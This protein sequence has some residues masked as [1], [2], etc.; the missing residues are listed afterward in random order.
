M[1]LRILTEEQALVIAESAATIA[2]KNLLESQGL[3][4]VKAENVISEDEPLH[5]VDDIAKHTGMH[6]GTIRR[7]ASEGTL[8]HYRAGKKLLFKKSEVDKALS[9][10][11]GQRRK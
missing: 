9:R 3:Q 11:R 8:P 7:M 1:S 6:P 4:L 2:L 5:T 10:T